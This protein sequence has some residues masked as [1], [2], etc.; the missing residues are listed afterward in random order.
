MTHTTTNDAHAAADAIAVTYARSLFDLSEEAGVAKEVGDELE[1]LVALLKAQPELNRMF[2]LQSIHPTRRAASIEA[3]FSGRVSDLTCRFLHVL[4][5]K[6][7]LGHL[8]ATTTAFNALLRKKHGEVDVQVWTAAPI[9]QALYDRLTEKLSAATGRAA[10]LH[11]RVDE[12]LLGG[13][14]L[15]IGDRQFDGSVAMQLQQLR[16]Q[17]IDSGQEAARRSMDKVI[18]D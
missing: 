8:A 14:K 10:V 7:R 3:I 5:R 2:S 17:L 4:N 15:R 12:D 16:K 9:D 13:L 6:D 11:H 1:Q 18:E